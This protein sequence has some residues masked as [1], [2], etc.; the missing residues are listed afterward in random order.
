MN[1]DDLL[2][3][4]RKPQEPINASDETQT[5]DLIALLQA[6]KQDERVALGIDQMA[7]RGLVVQ[8]H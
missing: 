2:R 3:L 4:T 6:Q 5:C 8:G 7:P 1:A